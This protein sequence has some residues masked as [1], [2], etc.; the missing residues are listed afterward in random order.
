[1]GAVLEELKCTTVIYS[2]Y[3]SLSLTVRQVEIQAARG[4]HFFD[5]LH[6]DGT[7][8]SSKEDSVLI[9][10]FVHFCFF[11]HRH[12]NEKTLSYDDFNATTFLWRHEL[13]SQRVCPSS[14]ILSIIDMP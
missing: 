1:M 9:R 13:S 7:R 2:A 11:Y 5:F 4:A 14:I 8:R 6:E 10:S 12:T 3:L